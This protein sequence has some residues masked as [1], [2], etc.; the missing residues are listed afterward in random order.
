MRCSDDR[1]SNTSHSRAARTTGV[2]PVTVGGYFQVT[3]S[4]RNPHTVQTRSVCSARVHVSR[5]YA[6][7]TQNGGWP[8]SLRYPSQR[9]MAYGRP[10]EE[11]ALPAGQTCCRL[12]SGV[13][14]SSIVGAGGTLPRTPSSEQQR[15]QRR[16]SSLRVTTEPLC[17]D[18]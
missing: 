8:T 2:T 17:A 3:T 1:R 13:A 4:V 14:S 18:H 11:E 15:R 6:R 12:A 9:P 16:E 5:R 10:P 7:T